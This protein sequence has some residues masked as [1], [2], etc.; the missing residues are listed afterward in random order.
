M[1]YRKFP[2]HTETP[3]HRDTPSGERV[4]DDTRRAAPAPHWQRN[5]LNGGG[6][7][8]C[9]RGRVQRRARR[10]RGASTRVRIVI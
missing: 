2:K 6:T 7:S 5:L 4:L 8:S 9:S 1:T 10:A 3:E